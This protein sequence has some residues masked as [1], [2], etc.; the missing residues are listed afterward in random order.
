M[1]VWI[2]NPYD[3]LPGE[4]ARPQR[5]W[6]MARAFVRAGHGVSLWTGDFSHATKAKRLK[7][8]DQDEK[9]IEVRMIPTLPYP[10]NL[11][12]SRIRSHRRLARDFER[13][14]RQLVG[15]ASAVRLR[16]SP[17]PDLV[18]AS[19]PPLALCSAAMRV[20]KSCGALFIADV[21]DAWPETFER[22]LPRF[23]WSLL[24]VRAAAKRIY[25]RADGVSAVAMRYVDLARSRG[26]DVPMRVFGHCIEGGRMEKAE[27]GSGPLRLVY[28]GNMSLSYDLETAIKAVRDLPGVTLDIAGNGPDRSRLQEL[29]AS[30]S[31]I[32][33]H[34]YLGERGLAELLRRCDV[35]IVPMFPESCVGVP[36]KLADYAAS[37]LR[38]IES[39]GGECQDIVEKYGAGAHYVA[40]NEDSLKKAV[41]VS[42]AP[43]AHYDP[44]AFAGH[45]DAVRVMDDF[46]GWCL[47]LM[48]CRQDWGSTRS[49]RC[50]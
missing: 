2:V 1:N 45:F 47:G 11:C 36:G 12:L 49:P 34:G 44:V 37:G 18:V 6:L 10:T 32:S 30:S 15:E 40:G 42:S 23:V 28:A 35:G 7:V 26:S 5:Y 48:R 22:I 16:P 27:R 4:G 21:Q 33:F 38:V 19:M 24:G 46:V 14:A 25:C 17:S 20:A 3:N 39:L 50:T 29:A 43:T 31:R 13:M 41:E 9:G 8:K